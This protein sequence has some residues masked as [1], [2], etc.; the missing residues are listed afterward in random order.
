MSYCMTRELED[1]VLG[2]SFILQIHS[3]LNECHELATLDDFKIF[4]CT[5]IRQILPHGM[6]MCGLGEIR[7]RRILRLINIDFP[8]GYL[9]RVIRP[10]QVIVGSPLK[11]WIGKRSPM[12]IGL[13]EIDE[14]EESVWHAA[15]CDF[16][17][18]NFACHGITDLS[19]NIF[20]YFEFGA[21]ETEK[22][23]YKVILN[24]VVPHLHAT[25]VRLLSE[26][27][28]S[29]RIEILNAEQTAASPNAP[30]PQDHGP[31]RFDITERQR[32]ILKWIAAGKSNW[33][34]GK[35]LLISEFTV[36]NHVQNVLKKLS[37]TTR[38]Q[39]AT[40]AISCGLIGEDRFYANL[41]RNSVELWRAGK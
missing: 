11:D 28:L 3:I 18:K 31:A 33:E 26:E 27:Y 30:L 37:V 22:F 14:K 16:G 24:L 12:M 35:I 25:L 2:N 9:R 38:A 17:I 23:S 13:D 36:K 5:R 29:S 32:E 8:P 10:D 21:V 40:K 19:G 1:A 34:I 39:A 15:A 20:T 6:A 41:D 7:S 4:I